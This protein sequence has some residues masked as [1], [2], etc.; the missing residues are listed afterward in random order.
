VDTG[1]QEQPPHVGES[2]VVKRWTLAIDAGSPTAV[3]MTSTT[4]EGSFRVSNVA[5]RVVSWPSLSRLEWR[6]CVRSAAQLGPGRADVL[7]GVAAILFERAAEMEVR[8]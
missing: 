4:I 7:A 6:H 5:K 1:Y 8:T 2:V 3:R